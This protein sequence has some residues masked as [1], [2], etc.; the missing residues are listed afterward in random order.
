MQTN[1]YVHYHCF[2]L[3]VQTNIHTYIQIKANTKHIQSTHIL[4]QKAHTCTK[5]TNILSTHIHSDTEHTHTHKEA[6]SMFK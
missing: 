1:V 5:H 3:H 4:T 2:L 6:E